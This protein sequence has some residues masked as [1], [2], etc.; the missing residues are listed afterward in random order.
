MSERRFSRDELVAA[1]VRYRHGRT[2]AFQDVDAAGIVFYP[3]FFEYFHD[4]YVAFLAERGASLHEA[5][6]K[7]IWAAPL[8]HASAD[9]FRPLRFGDPIDVLIV[10]SALEES[11]VT[12]GYRV[13][14]RGSDDAVAVGQAVHVF[15]DPTTFK[16]AA[17][18]AALVAVM[19]TLA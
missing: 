9:Y 18:P 8:K 12:L 5:I 19:R 15:V 13:T 4:A 10:A 11:S 3:R 16:R 1:P 17:P 7:K 14:P 6:N 2:V